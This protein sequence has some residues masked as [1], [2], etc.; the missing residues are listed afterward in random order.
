MLKTTNKQSNKWLNK[1]KKNIISVT[2]NVK[3]HLSNFAASH[4]GMQ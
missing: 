3:M 2:M 1:E 4:A